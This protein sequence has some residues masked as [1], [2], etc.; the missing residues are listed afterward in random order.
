MNP[1]LKAALAQVDWLRVGHR[2]LTLSRS[3][4][5]DAELDNDHQAET[6]RASKLLATLD[7]V[8]RQSVNCKAPAAC[9]C[10]LCGED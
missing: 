8:A 3:L 1:E 6:G 5:G 9:A 7:G 4:R 2:L 10:P